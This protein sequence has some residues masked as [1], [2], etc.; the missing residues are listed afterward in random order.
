MVLTVLILAPVGGQA[1][2]VIFD[3]TNNYPTKAIRIE[4]LDVDGTF[5]NVAFIYNTAAEY[6][7]DG[8][9]GY[10]DFTTQE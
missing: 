2:D 7:Y 5:Y 3:T 10:F 9:P 6:V 1:A 8:P 4:N